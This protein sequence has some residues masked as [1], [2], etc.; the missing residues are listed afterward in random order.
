MVLFSQVPN[1][2]SLHPFFCL[3]EMQMFALSASL[4]VFSFVIQLDIWISLLS[5]TVVDVQM[6]EKKE[7][8]KF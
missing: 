6:K 5:G 1:S 4:M 3:V 2:D 7:N 8:K